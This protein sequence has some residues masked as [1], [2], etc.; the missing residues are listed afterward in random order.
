MSGTETDVITYIFQGMVKHRET[1][2]RPGDLNESQAELKKNKQIIQ[3]KFQ[4]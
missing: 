1:Q 2:A 3:I 4:F